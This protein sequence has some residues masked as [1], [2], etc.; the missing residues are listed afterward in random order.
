MIANSCHFGMLF[1]GDQ[2]MLFVMQETT[3][4]QGQVED[5]MLCSR[6][7]DTTT[8]TGARTAIQVSIA[9]LL[10]ERYMFLKD[11]G[12]SAGIAGGTEVQRPV[13]QPASGG[14]GKPLTTGAAVATSGMASHI[15]VTD[16]AILPAVSGN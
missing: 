15:A 12:L 2:F 7:L 13:A 3:D 8:T 4:S 16:M 1:G 14:H 9:M 10:G 6:I 11:Q 5:Q